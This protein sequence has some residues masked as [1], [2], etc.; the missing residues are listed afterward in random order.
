M[1]KPPSVREVTGWICRRPDHL[2]E[3]YVGRLRAL[4]DRC[5]ELAAAA[6]LVRSFADMLTSLRG[7][8]LGA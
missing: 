5:P 1:A 2:V 8:R 3:R 4:L 7:D 6:E